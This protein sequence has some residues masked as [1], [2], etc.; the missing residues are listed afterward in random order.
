MLFH[1]SAFRESMGQ[2][3]YLMADIVRLSLEDLPAQET[4]LKEH[5]ESKNW[6]Q[7]SRSAHAIKGVALSLSAQELSAVAQRLEAASRTPDFEEFSL[8]DDVSALLETTSQA[9]SE[10][11]RKIEAEISESEA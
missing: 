8:I 10:F 2:D 5:R 7:V 3:P 4:R 11:L 1:E 6:E 9:L